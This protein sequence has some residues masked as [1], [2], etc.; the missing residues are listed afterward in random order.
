ML[1][2]Q[3]LQPLVQATTDQQLFTPL[4]EHHQ[5]GSRARSK[6]QGQQPGEQRLIIHGLGHGLG[7][8]PRGFA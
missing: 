7:H 4:S 3:Q 2:M 1:A 6:Q 5:T 8:G